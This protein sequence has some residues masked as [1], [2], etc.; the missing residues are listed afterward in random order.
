MRRTTRA[1]SLRSHAAPAPRP[2]KDCGPRGDPHPLLPGASRRRAE[3]RRAMPCA[4]VAPA[5]RSTSEDREETSMDKTG[6]AMG[7]DPSLGVREMAELARQAELR[8]YDMAFFS[9]A[10]LCNRDSVTAL[11][12]F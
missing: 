9:E 12:A 11:A 3:A 7:Y 4:R 8:G 2:S 5:A 1:T 6:F 10:L